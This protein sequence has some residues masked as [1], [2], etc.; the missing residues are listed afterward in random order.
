MGTRTEGAQPSAFQR[1]RYGTALEAARRLNA[2]AEGRVKRDQA[3][4][5]PP[6]QPRR[7]PEDE[8]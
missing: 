6:P 5:E 7:S 8:G 4:A 1:W 3:T 2:A